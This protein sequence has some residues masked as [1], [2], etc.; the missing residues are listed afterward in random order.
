MNRDVRESRLRVTRRRALMAGGSIGLGALLAACGVDS[1][2]GSGG[3]AS[4]TDAASEAG[5]TGAVAA[6]TTGD[7]VES[8]LVAML[9]GSGRCEITPEETEGP[10]W[11]DVDSIRRDI[12]EDRPGT[13]LELALRVQDTS[14]CSTGGDPVPIEAC[15]VEIW[16]CDAGGEYSGFESGTLGGPGGGPGG[17]GGELSDG[18]YSSGDDQA[19]PS[20]DG[21]YL[22]GAQAAGGDGI[23][24][25]TTIYPGWYSGRTVHIHLKV[26]IDRATALTSQLYMD[27]ELSDRVHATSPYDDHAGRD[28]DNSTDGIFDAS[29]LLVVEESDDGY[30]AAIN[31]GIDR[32]A[33]AGAVATSGGAAA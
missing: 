32:S 6:T 8:R 14:A 23:A 22:R 7:S 12:R 33:S 27:D 15:V 1:G 29:G 25:F 21:T 10:Y 24:R 5:R 30:L 2:E 28:T 16:H 26:H 3:T 9:D 18:S 17:G 19:S 11:F 4:S 13:R 20:D 31:L